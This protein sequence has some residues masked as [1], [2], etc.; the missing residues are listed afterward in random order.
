MQDFPANSAK[1]RAQSQPPRGERP[2]RIERVTSVEASRRRRG[3]GRKFKEAFIGGTAQ[4][5]IDY[6]VTDIVVPAIRDLMFDAFE[7]GLDRLIYGDSRRS[8][9][10]G[11]PLSYED[12]NRPQV[13]YS[14]MSTSTSRPP[15]S[16]TR[17]LSRR[18]RA[19]HDFDDI[20][21]S[22]RAEAQEVLDQM[23]ELLSR[24]D[25]VL[26]SELYEMTGI[27]SSH[28]DHKWGWT[29]LS[30][31]KIARLRNNRGFV[32]DLPEPQPLGV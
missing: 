15:T 25:V 31:A 9:R 14:G 29:S 12:I 32:L 13:N 10:N 21:I 28:N 6:M 2:K 23:Y 17:M 26:V 3:V 22:S 4:M 20:I 30:G 24:S 16:S 5:A 8:R 1:A 27:Q 18:S 19:R 11:R 7:G